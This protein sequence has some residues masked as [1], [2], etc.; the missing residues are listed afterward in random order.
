MHHMCRCGWSDSNRC[1]ACGQKEDREHLL[2]CDHE[3]RIEWRK[4]LTSA[5]RKT[6]ENL[7]TDYILTNTLA[8]AITYWLDIGCVPK[9]KFPPAFQHAIQAQDR[10][11]WIN[12]FC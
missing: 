8:S 6:M 10:I 1:K 3:D 11:G 12:L 9:R 4:R 5:L 7:N 2:R